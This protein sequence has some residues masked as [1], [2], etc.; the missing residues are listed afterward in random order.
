MG[1]TFSVWPHFVQFLSFA[2]LLFSFSYKT[3]S[4]LHV[5]KKKVLRIS[6]W[7]DLFTWN[8][9]FWIDNYDSS[10]EIEKKLKFEKPDHEP[11][12]LISS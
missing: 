6:M 11:V 10:N 2:F 12:S 9:Y 3:P 7:L 4:T 1:R 5:Q 8:L